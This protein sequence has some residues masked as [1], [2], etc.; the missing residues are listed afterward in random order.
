MKVLVSSDDTGAAKLVV[1]K[2]GT[3]TSKKD[4]T[5]PSLVK[6]CLARPNS[7]Y[8][9]RIAHLLNYDYQYLIASRYG[10]VVSIYDFE[11]AEQTKE[12]GQKE[13]E[14]EQELFTHIKDY[15]IPIEKDDKPVALC[16]SE[17]LDSVLLAYESGKVFLL[18]LGNLEFEPFELDVPRTGPISAFTV[19]QHQENVVAYGGKENDL[20]IVEL[21]DSKLNSN[22][23]KGD[24]KCAL[25]PKTIFKAK[26]VRNDH[27][28]LRVPIWIT[29][30][31]FFD[32]AAKKG[33]YKLITSTRYG[34]LRL[35]DMAHGRKPTNDFQVTD[36]AILR[37]AF[38]D[39]EQTQVVVTDTHSLIA[40]YSLS[41]IDKRAFKTN[42]ASAGDIIKPVPRLLGKFAGG[43]TG[44]TFAVQVYDNVAAFGGLDRYLRAFNTDDRELLAKIYLG[45]EISSLI[46]LDD[47]DEVDKEEQD[48]K[49]KREEEEAHEE[50]EM[51]NQLSKK[52]DVR[53]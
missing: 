21:F 43:N 20:Q 13:Q 34:Q 4:S 8:K 19:N 29:N 10:G 16:K 48:Q 27:L 30:I 35:Y 33:Q 45:V 7:S 24:Y 36:S 15:Q 44:A 42:S 11:E 53:Y 14:Q 28:D 3:D 52:R 49:R 40:K 18:Y 6:N 17:K 41:Q 50:E 5:G 38:A 39:D 9:T 46:I 12:E 51:W 2:K 31:L 47:E 22:V 26:N 23:F 1:F 25:K 32:N 37:L